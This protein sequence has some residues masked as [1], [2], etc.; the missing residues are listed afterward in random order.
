MTTWKM[1]VLSKKVITNLLGL[2]KVKEAK[3][4]FIYVSIGNE[5]QTH[6]LIKKF[7]KEGKIVTVPKVIGEGLMDVYQIKDWHQ[8]KPGKYNILS[9]TTMRPYKR[10]LDVCIAPSVAVTEKRHRLGRGRGY[11]DRFIANH[12]GMFIV[13]LTFNQQIVSRIPL[14]QT[15]KLVDIIVTEDRIIR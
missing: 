13:A 3:S 15:D 11:Y 14:D 4:F 1:K 2:K 12:S 5:V 6:D 9:P 7:L 8:L 10:K